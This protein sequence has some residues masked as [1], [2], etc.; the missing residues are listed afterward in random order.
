M[1][2]RYVKF[3]DFYDYVFGLGKYDSL[4]DDEK[5]TDFIF[6][7]IAFFEAGRAV[8]LAPQQGQQNDF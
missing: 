7:L 4:T 1:I 6:L 3:S 5:Q 2:Y 8:D